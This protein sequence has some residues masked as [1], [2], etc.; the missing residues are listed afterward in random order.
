MLACQG[1]KH[2]ASWQ[3][4]KVL[5]LTA[6][7]DDEVMFFAPTILALVGMGVQVHAL[8]LSI[9]NAENLGKIRQQELINSYASL[10]VPADHIQSVDDS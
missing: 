3:P 6:H 5:I 2:S 7:P 4:E 9:G 8:C 10:G 1:L